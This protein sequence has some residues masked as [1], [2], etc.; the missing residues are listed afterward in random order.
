MLSLRKETDYAIQFL[1]YL[2]KNGNCS[3]KK[4]SGKSGI[5]FF[6]MQKIARKLTRAGIVKA[7]QGV[8]GGY[9][10]D[11]PVKKITLYKILEIMEGGVGLT[12]CLCGSSCCCVNSQKKCGARKVIGKLNREILKLAKKIRVV[13]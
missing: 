5:S 8:N 2:A 11:L 7:E 4:F 6:F 10:L 13:E 9:G 3:L 1:Q 12:S